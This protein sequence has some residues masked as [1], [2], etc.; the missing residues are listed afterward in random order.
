M[1]LLHF[2]RNILQLVLAPSQAW[3]DI[4]NEDTLPETLTSRGLYPMMALMLVT[5]FIRPLYGI[6]DFDLI[7]L[8]Q[9]ALVQFVALF[10]ALYAGRSVMEH[11][12]PSYNATAERDPIATYTV[13]IYGTGLM[14]LIQMIENLLPI[15]L[16]VIQLL[17]AFAAV[18]IWKSDK[19]L[20]LRPQGE[21]PFMIISILSLIAPVILIN[22]LMSF[23]MS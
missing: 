14:V 4:E 19:Y 11:F 21:V 7:R 13:A 15:E 17:P 5:V 6:G 16:T 12:L 10:I 3:K 9:T 1:A 23:L 20:D 18:C 2:L 8:L 22:M